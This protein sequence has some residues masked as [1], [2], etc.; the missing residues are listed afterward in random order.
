MIELND[1]QARALES[2]AE[3]PPRVRNPRTQET[4]VLVRE[5]VYE[6]VRKIIDGYNRGGWDDPALDV[7]EE[8]RSQP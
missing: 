3:A 6:T 7:Y 1:E 5:D 4:F 2:Q 8:Y